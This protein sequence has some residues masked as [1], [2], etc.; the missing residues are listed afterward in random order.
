MALKKIT[1]FISLPH[2]K[3]ASESRTA[4]IRTPKLLIIPMSQHIGAPC[5]PTV[6]VGER[7]FEGQ[8]IGNTE[9]FVSAPIHASSS[10]KVKEIREITAMSGKRVKAVVIETDI[11]SLPLPGVKP[12]EINRYGKASDVG[13]DEGR[14]SFLEAVRDSG[15]VGMGGAGFPTHVKLAFDRDKTDIHTLLVNGAECEPYITSD[16]REFLENADG[17][18]D[19]IKHVMHWLKIHRVI[20]GIEK[21]K[22]KAIREMNSR[23]PE[24]ADFGKQSGTEVTAEVKVLPQKYPQGAEKVLIY[25][26]TGK[27]VPSGQLPSFMGCVVI[28][29]TTLGVIS[30]YIRTGM[31]LTK[32][33]VTV[34]G[35]VLNK[36]Q[37]LW[38]PLG[39]PLSEI[40]AQLNM[41]KKPD[42]I[43]FGGPMMGS[44]VYD[45][46]QPVTKPNNAILFLES[47]PN[48]CTACIRCGRC[49]SA[50]CM[51]LQPVKINES[52]TARNIEEL[53]RLDV[54]SCL[55]CGACSYVCPARRNVAE[56]NQLAKALIPKN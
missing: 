15:A 56:T 31:P 41:R 34:D 42:K 24:L 40:M 36:A 46:L 53:R 50:C 21:D 2:I 9:A 12:P 10:G 8:V 5:S 39:T 29:P 20:I 37:N 44:A 28:N 48:R 33:R 26:A 17:I 35:D 1:N 30:K 51:N 22:P 4:D 16:Y 38:V 11:D 32:R 55:N 52:F 18:I 54:L 3:N 13:Y 19:G 27:V 43:I 23:L 14:K 6:K 45:P 25:Q 47:A 49:I 7:V